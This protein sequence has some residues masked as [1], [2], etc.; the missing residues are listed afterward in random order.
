MSEPATAINLS[1]SC[2]LD[3]GMLKVIMATAAYQGR[4]VERTL[5]L[6]QVEREDIEQD[7]LLVLLERRRFFDPS[8]GP[9]TPFAH[10][11]ARQAAQSAADRLVADSARYDLS[12]DQPTDNAA[13]DDEEPAT[14]G[15]LTAD[16]A[17]PTE[18][19]I[20]DALSLIRFIHELP[21][22]LR[23]LAEAALIAD[24]DLA[25]AR[26]TLGLSTSEFY[27]RLREIRY[28][29]FTVCL[30]NRRTLLDP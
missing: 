6:S 25:D 1:E 5:K 2:T 4:R 14:I 29:M 30:V 24:G 7:I 17:A 28:R 19:N 18:A 9:W 11:I 15:N 27:R 23:A 10:R 21:P 8:R 16:D 13:S 12:L 22:E 20:L 26:R 3:A